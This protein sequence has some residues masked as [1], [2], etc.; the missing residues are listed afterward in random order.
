[1]KG[2][3]RGHFCKGAGTWTERDKGSRARYL[4]YFQNQS[5]ETSIVTPSTIKAYLVW[6]LSIHVE[7]EFADSI[8]DIKEAAIPCR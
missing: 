6:A 8:Q 3:Q 5:L 2:I 4:R 1:M 7:K